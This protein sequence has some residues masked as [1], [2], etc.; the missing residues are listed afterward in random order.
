MTFLSD[1]HDA[2]EAYPSPLRARD[3][4]TQELGKDY[5]HMFVDGWGEQVR[6][7]VFPT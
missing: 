2:I 3:L 1:L 5:A 6:R 7:R 4:G